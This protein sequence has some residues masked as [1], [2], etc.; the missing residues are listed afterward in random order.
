MKSRYIAK[1]F[2]PGKYHVCD[3]QKF[4]LPVYDN[5]RNGHDKPLVF[6]EDDAIDYAANLNAAHLQALKGLD[7]IT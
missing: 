5:V 6:N 2:F 3:S 4:D 1:E 7:L